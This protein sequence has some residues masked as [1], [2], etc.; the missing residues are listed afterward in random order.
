MLFINYILWLIATIIRSITWEVRSENCR[1]ACAENYVGPLSSPLLRLSSLPLLF[2]SIS[3][4]IHKTKPKVISP[5]VNMFNVTFI[6]IL[7][8]LYSYILP[9]NLHTIHFVQCYSNL[10]MAGLIF[11]PSQPNYVHFLSNPKA[12]ETLLTGFSSL[13]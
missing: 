2:L 11:L 4:S 8:T 7:C 12:G 6:L 9:T 1:L 5:I 10:F 3:I 13:F